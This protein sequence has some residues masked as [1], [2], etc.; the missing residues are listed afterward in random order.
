[1]SQAFV[2]VVENEALGRIANMHLAICDLLAD[3]ARDPLAIELAKAHS[4]AVDYPKTGVAPEMPEV[5]R[6]QGPYDPWLMIG[7][8]LS[9]SVA[10]LRRNELMHVSLYRR[11]GNDGR[12]HSRPSPRDGTRTSWKGESLGVTRS[13]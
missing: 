8:L 5:R 2:R 13:G 1:M 11:I 10:L 9:F 4:L 3:G 7:C 12:R 6:D